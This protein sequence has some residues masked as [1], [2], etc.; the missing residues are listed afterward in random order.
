MGLEKLNEAREAMQRGDKT[1]AR[2]LIRQ[3]LLTNPHNEQ[4]WL[5]MA[6]VVE[7]HQQV[8]DCLE[9]ALKINPGNA[10][11]SQ[12]LR[13]IQH[14]HSVQIS[15]SAPTTQIASRQPVKSIQG[16]IN[17]NIRP[18]TQAMPDIGKPYVNSEVRQTPRQKMN[19]SLLLGILIV[20]I[21]I[22]VA[23]IGPELAPKD[24]MEEITIL[25]VGDDWVIPPFHAFAVPGYILGTD[26]FGRDMLSRILWAVRPTL[27]MVSI[28]AM[29]RLFLGTL[30]GLGAGWSAG[31]V[32]RFLGTLISA[33]LAIPIL[34]VALGSIAI[35]GAE[36]GL[37]AFIIGLSINGWGETARI[38]R[39]QTQIIKGQPYIEATLAIGASPLQILMRHI[40]RQIMPMVWMLFTFEISGT[41]MVSAA[42]GFL[43]YYIGGDVWVE[44]GDLISRRIAG[45]PELG[46]MLATSWVTLL[47]PW[48]LFLTGSVIFITILGF[49]L[50]GA[51]LRA[52]LN[53]EF[54]NRNNPVEM[55]SHK[56]SMWFEQYV[57][58]PVF[59]WF[60]ANRLRPTMVFALIVVLT[61][62]V[63]LWHT[64]FSSISNPI[65]E[66]LSI[67]GGQLWAA[68]RSDPYGTHWIQA[69]GP[70]NPQAL[71]IFKVPAGFSGSPVISSEGIIYAAVLDRRLMALNP[72]GTVRWEASMSQMPIGPLTLGP[73]GIIYVS[74]SKGGMS[75]FSPEG[76]PL[77]TFESDAPGKSHHGAIVAPNGTIYYLLEYA[78][79]DTLLALLPNGERLWSVQLDT[80]LADRELRLT[81]DGGLIF[82]RN[83]AINAVDGSIVDLSL[84][85]QGSDDIYGRE[86]LMA[87]ADGKTYLLD[88]YIVTQWQQTP[89]G[90]SLL[91]TTNWD[92]LQTQEWDWRGTENADPER[93]MPMDAGVTP[94]GKIWLYSVSWQVGTSLYW[95]DLTG[96]ILSSYS[97]PTP[98]GE[99]GRI[100]AVDGADVAYICATVYGTDLKGWDIAIYDL[101]EAYPPDGSAPLWSYI[102]DAEANGIVGTAMAPGRLYVIT[103]DGTLT[104]LTDN[105]SISPLTTNTP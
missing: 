64:K 104:A 39:E 55:L 9:Q 8:V 79:G 12:A 95:L 40:L 88:G 62:S 54:I 2:R 41:L 59:N 33:A 81:P 36:T 44:V 21:V 101:C 5:M 98:Y 86:Q 83:V 99:S 58:Y 17:S 18:E 30:I 66:T 6:G 19:W 87:G 15:P 74:D 53:P 25:K 70:T 103:G 23:I 75:A 57:S 78:Y 96:K 26:Q 45:V 84:P 67:P 28:V 13:A 77:W 63:Y 52:R 50:L 4:A 105:G 85:I 20:L 42:L 47:D 97:N 73:Q 93:F 48:P 102:L 16:T 82:L 68:E 31:W 38:V 69:I 92:W 46:Q 11:A 29:V 22:L 89:Q 32:G 71:W 27:I 43:G 24:P 37:L 60:R 100:V 90:S 10:S 94:Q 80:R 65:L 49:S 61:C 7:K 56:F 35:M 51:G 76:H 72:D 1:H 3:V 34:L 91:Q 14:E